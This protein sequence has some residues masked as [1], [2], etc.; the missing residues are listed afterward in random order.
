MEF[1]IVMEASPG[2]T[3]RLAAEIEAMGFDLLLCPDTQ[4][5]SPEPFS[6][7]ALAAQ[8]VQKRSVGIEVERNRERERQIGADEELQQ[9]HGQRDSGGAAE[10]RQY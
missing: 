5:L 4:N 7:L 1:G 2:Y 8:T 3:A 10:K 6:Q 9:H